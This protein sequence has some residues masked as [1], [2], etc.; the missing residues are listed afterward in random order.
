M[1]ES[2]SELSATAKVVYSRYQAGVFA[3]DDVAKLLTAGKITEQE[4][5]FIK[6]E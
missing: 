4:S 2:Y 3:E 5:E 6:G 1:I